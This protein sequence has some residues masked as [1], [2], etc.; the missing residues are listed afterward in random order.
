MRA[1]LDRREAIAESIPGRMAAAAR[2]PLS[3]FRFAA[4]LIWFS[5]GI[6]VVAP[7]ALGEFD[8]WTRR[9]VDA[10][11]GADWSAALGGRA[12]D[13]PG[14]IVAFLEVETREPPTVYRSAPL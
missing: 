14:L 11:D 6:L 9:R 3:R 12:S 1:A 5:A 8:R 7:F 13:L 2:A 10:R 4:Y